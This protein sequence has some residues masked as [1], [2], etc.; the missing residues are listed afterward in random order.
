MTWSAYPSDLGPR[1][2]SAGVASTRA[3]ASDRPALPLL[4]PD[5]ATIFQLR[6]SPGWL[7]LDARGR[8]H[9]Q[10]QVFELARG[11][12]SCLAPGR[13]CPSSCLDTPGHQEPRP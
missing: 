13:G 1:R 12:A 8:V 2:S 10:A 7:T 6:P 4:R 9:E 11:F 3:T 5:R